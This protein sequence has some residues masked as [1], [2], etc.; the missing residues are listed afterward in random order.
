MSSD[1]VIMN[2]NVRADGKQSFR[3]REIETIF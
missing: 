1:C 3:I 2:Q